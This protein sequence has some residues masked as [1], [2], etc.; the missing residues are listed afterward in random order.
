MPGGRSKWHGREPDVT[1]LKP[2]LQLDP[3]IDPDCATSGTLQRLIENSSHSPVGRYFA[4]YAELP[5]TILSDY[6]KPMCC[7]QS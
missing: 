5:L 6:M 4:L 1:N 3:G 2:L 7:M